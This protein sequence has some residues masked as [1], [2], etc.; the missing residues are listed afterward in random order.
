MPT[1]NEANNNI[2]SMSKYVKVKSSHWVWLVDYLLRNITIPTNGE[3]EILF[4]LFL[5][6]WNFEGDTNLQKTD[7]ENPK[8]LVVCIDNLHI[9]LEV[10][11]WNLQ[12]YYDEDLVFDVSDSVEQHRMH[13]NLSRWNQFKMLS[14]Y[15]TPENITLTVLGQNVGG[16][17]SFVLLDDFVITVRARNITL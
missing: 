17:K 2:S 7:E 5:Y 14:K 13:Y 16:S 9:Y 12:I 8:F 4:R 6:G 15:K 1:Q 3:L 10:I 11:L